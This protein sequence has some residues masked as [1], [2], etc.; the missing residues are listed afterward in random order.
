MTGQTRGMLA[1]SSAPG[2]VRK[3]CLMGVCVCVH[4]GLRH[5]ILL[6]CQHPQVDQ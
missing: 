2:P 4:D 1:V 5:S 3:A 6:G